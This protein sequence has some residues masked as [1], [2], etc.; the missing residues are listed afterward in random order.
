LPQPKAGLETGI[1]KALARQLD[2]QVVTLS[3]PQVT[4]ESVLTPPSWA[5]AN[6]EKLS[7]TAKVPV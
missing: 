5:E 4:T 6:D 1:V 2:S 3:C 7:L